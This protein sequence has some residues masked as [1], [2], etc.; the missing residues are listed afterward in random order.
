MVG[1]SN[2]LSTVTNNIG[3]QKQADSECTVMPS[4]GVQHHEF[5]N[6]V[7][8]RVLLFMVLSFHPCSILSVLYSIFHHHFS[9]HETSY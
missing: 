2:I 5:S 4:D 9:P 8:L 3:V 1:A 7:F 6:C